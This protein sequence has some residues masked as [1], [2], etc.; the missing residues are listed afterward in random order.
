MQKAHP[1]TPVRDFEV[2]PNVSFARVD[3]VSGDPVSPVTRSRRNP[4]VWSPFVRG[5]IPAKHL[6]GP[7]VRAFEDLV[8]PPMPAPIAR[9][10]SLDCL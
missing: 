7:P 1:R 2:P 6:G 8:A 5:T 3:P 4:P 10:S 9:C